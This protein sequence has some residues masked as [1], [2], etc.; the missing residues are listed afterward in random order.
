MSN[1]ATF[2]KSEQGW[3]IEIPDE[4]AENI[5]IEKNSIGLLGYKDGKIVVEILPPPSEKIKDISNRLGEKY[6]D[7][8]AEMKRIGD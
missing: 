2:Q 8:F 5:G 3:I 4:F 6:K 7:F 1:Q